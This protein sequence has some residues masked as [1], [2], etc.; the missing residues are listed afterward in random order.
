[1]RGTNC[2]NR[3][4]ANENINT[5]NYFNKTLVKMKQM[6]LAISKLDYMSIK[7]QRNRRKHM[8]YVEKITMCLYVKRSNEI[9]CYWSSCNS[10]RQY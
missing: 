7:T 10:K 5:I 1:M 4:E 2:G 3:I 8:H 6:W 9:L